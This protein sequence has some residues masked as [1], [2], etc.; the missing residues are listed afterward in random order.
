MPEYIINTIAKQFKEE[1]HRRFKVLKEVRANNKLD[2][3]KQDILIISSIQDCGLG[4]RITTI[5][6]VKIV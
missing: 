1:M 4:H 5:K 6:G 3:T 2:L